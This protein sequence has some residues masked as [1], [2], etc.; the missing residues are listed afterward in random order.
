MTHSETQPPEAP[1]PVSRWRFRPYHWLAAI[2]TVV[3]MGGIPFVNR[4]HPMVLGLPLLMAWILAW[5]IIT[6]GIMGLI[7]YL[8]RASE[9]GER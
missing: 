1:T 2:P 6:A 8:D 4:V 5:V 3:M 7:L 9:R